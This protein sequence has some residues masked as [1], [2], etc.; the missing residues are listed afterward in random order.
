PVVRTEIPIVQPNTEWWPGWG[1]APW[2]APRQCEV[3]SRSRPRLNAFDPNHPSRAPGRRPTAGQKIPSRHPERR[4]AA[5]TE[6]SLRCATRN[7]AAPGLADGAE[8]STWL[9]TFPLRLDR[10]RGVPE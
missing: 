3:T 1:V 2:F 6:I 5:R 7:S 10:Q 4:P 9:A 8:A